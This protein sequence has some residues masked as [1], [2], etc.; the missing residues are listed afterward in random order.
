MSI[1]E[2]IPAR[3]RRILKRVAGMNSSPTTP[4]PVE[5][6]VKDAQEYWAGSESAADRRDMSH[7]LGEGR[8]ADE[9]EWR[10]IGEDHFKLYE[11]LLKLAGRTDP[12]R[13]MMEWGQG[14][15]ANAICFA[16]EVSDY[17]GVDI[18]EPNLKECAR[19]LQ[20]RGH[21]NFRGILIDAPNPEGVLAQCDRPID[22]FLSTAVFQ[23][24]PNKEY[25]VRVTKA[26]HQLLADDGIALIQTRYDNG[27]DFF[28]SKARDYKVNVVAFTSYMIDEYWNVARDAGFRPLAVILS[29]KTNYAYYLLAKS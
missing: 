22:F 15:G 14:G 11:T 29:P 1:R 3:A 17:I 20:S 21:H 2:L 16:R 28:K 13:T 19:Q 9:A 5:V 4:Q 26:A 6:I 23:H 7:W 27:T 18:S 12:V 10:R 25:G 8:W 24:F